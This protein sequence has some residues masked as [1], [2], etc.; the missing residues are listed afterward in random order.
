MKTF[1]WYKIP[2]NIRRFIGITILFILGYLAVSFGIK[3]IFYIL[4][5]GTTVIDKFFSFLVSLF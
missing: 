1:N 4:Y 2:I 5:A 3:L